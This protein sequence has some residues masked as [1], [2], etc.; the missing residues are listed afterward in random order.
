MTEYFTT[1]GLAAECGITTRSV[2][3]HKK[4]KLFGLDKAYTR[5][6]GVGWRFKAHLVRDYIS[7]MK[8]KQPN[9]PKQPA[10][11]ATPAEMAM[12]GYRVSPRLQQR[13]NELA[14]L[15]PDTTPDAVAA[16][17]MR[18]ALNSLD[19]G[20]ATIRKV[21]DDSFALAPSEP[22]PP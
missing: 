1:E 18:Y 13:V 17:L 21:I 19:A 6:K 3:K 9:N 12:I 16:M 8:A 5:I 11:G 10:N 22:P 14:A 7:A 4:A 20:R 2:Q 15:Y